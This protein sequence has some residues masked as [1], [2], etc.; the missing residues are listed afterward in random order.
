[1]FPSG[2]VGVQ[3]EGHMVDWASMRDKQV[4][5]LGEENV[6]DAVGAGC[7]VGSQF[8][9]GPVYFFI[10]DAAELEAGGQVVIF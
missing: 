8:G 1:M 10:R 3:L 6:G 2:R 4:C 9:D 5:A 7:F